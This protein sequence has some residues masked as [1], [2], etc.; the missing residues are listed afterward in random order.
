MTRTAAWIATGVVAV[1]LGLS[2]GA[3]GLFD[4]FL[5]GDDRFAA[6]RT[7]VVAGN[8][9]I[10][11]P[12]ELLDGQGRTVTNREVLNRPALVYFGYSFCPEACPLD[13]ARN[14]TAV[15]MLAERGFAVRPVFISIDPARDTPDVVASYAQALH[16]DMIG[17]TGSAEQVAAAARAYRVFFAKRDSDDPEFYLMDHSTF[18]YLVLPDHGF[19]EFLRS[20]TA[21]DAAADQIACY[22]K[23]A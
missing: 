1:F 20:D 22:L 10:G 13:L 5:R 19:V 6:C 7:G 2:F 17:L 8:A 16:P 4:A 23:K 11:G 14:A 18:S 3:A 21:P 9:A 15:D 12:F